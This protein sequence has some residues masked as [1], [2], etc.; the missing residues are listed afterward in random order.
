MRDGPVKME[1]EAPPLATHRVERAL[2]PAKRKMDD[3]DIKD[4]DLERQ[5]PRPPPFANGLHRP[6][7]SSRPAAAHHSD[8]PMPARRRPR[9]V[10][11]PIWAVPYDR[12]R[13]KNGNFYL[14]KPHINQPQV[15]GKP[16]TTNP[17]PRPEQPDSRHVSPEASRANVP[18]PVV[19]QPSP[20]PVLPNKPTM[21]GLWEPT[22]ANIAPLDDMVNSVA[23]F[24]FVHVV[25]Q[26]ELTKLHGQKGFHFEIEAKL[27]FLAGQGGERFRFQPP[28]SSEA[29]LDPYANYAPSFVSDM[30]EVSAVK[31][32]CYLRDTNEGRHMLIMLT[33]M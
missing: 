24:L 28:L 7:S 9:H 18:G 10:Q 15:N 30:D 32:R 29:V 19:T 20:A 1:R 6:G 31:P 26:S 12:Q 27:G 5:E 4:E 21:L 17:V 16:K 8:A 2:T 11:P 23:D 3:R 14:R 22:I 33:T 25:Q 13:L